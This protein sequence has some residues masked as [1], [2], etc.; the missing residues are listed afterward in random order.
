[1]TVFV[2]EFEKKIVNTDENND[3]NNNDDTDGNHSELTQKE[4]IYLT[5]T[6]KLD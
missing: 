4:T 3:S 2:A 5:P 6:R 1:M